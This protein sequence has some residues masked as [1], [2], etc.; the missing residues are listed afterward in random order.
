MGPDISQYEKFTKSNQRCIEEEET[1]NY[2][3]Q[4]TVRNNEG[5]FVVHLPKKSTV[6]ELGATLAMATSRL[7]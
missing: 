2:F 3:N 1:V 7:V 6:H 4:T 5:R